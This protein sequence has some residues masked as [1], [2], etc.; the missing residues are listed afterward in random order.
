MLRQRAGYPPSSRKSLFFYRALTLV[1]VWMRRALKQG[2]GPLA[3]LFV[4]VHR[5]DYYYYCTDVYS[6]LRQFRM[7][8]RMAFEITLLVVLPASRGL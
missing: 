7:L 5:A 6:A 4:L 2:V 3:F 8:G 1:S